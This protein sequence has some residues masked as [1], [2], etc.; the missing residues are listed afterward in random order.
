LNA[1]WGITFAA[2]CATFEEWGS[3]FGVI[4]FAFL[5]K[6]A[7]DLA[8]CWEEEYKIQSDMVADISRRQ[9]EMQ[10][11]MAECYCNITWANI[12]ETYACVMAYECFDSCVDDWPVLFPHARKEVIC[13]L[14]TEN[15]LANRYCIDMDRRQCDN[16]LYAVAL[17]ATAT[18]ACDLKEHSERRYLARWEQKLKFMS[19]MQR[20]L[21]TDPRPINGLLQNALAIGNSVFSGSSTSS[22]GGGDLG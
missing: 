3:T 17:M 21:W 13:A 10:K 2:A 12:Q 18:A 22:G 7:K 11:A 19:A 8:D 9:L 14:N 4:G 15:R 5:A 20:L 1:A 16:E 6:Q